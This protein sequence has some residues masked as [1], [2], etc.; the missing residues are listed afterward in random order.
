[1]NSAAKSSWRY[2]NIIEELNGKISTA[3]NQAEAKTAKQ[4][5]ET[6]RE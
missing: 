5:H 3:I 2:I 4:K 1:M 6:T